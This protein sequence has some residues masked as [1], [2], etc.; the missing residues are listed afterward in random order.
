MAKDSGNGERIPMLADV[1]GESLSC[2][3]N[4][5]VLHCAFS[6]SPENLFGGDDF[7]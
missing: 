7:V 6:A 4:N 2:W 5:L 1:T 3:Q